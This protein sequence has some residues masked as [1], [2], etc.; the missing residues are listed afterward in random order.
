MWHLL[1]RRKSNKL[2]NFGRE[3]FK[4]HGN[5]LRKMLI[6]C[7]FA[8]LKSRNSSPSSHAINWKRLSTSSTGFF[9]P[10]KLSQIAL[11][12]EY[13]FYNQHTSFPKRFTNSH[14]CLDFQDG[15]WYWYHIWKITR[16]LSSFR[17]RRV[18]YIY[19]IGHKFWPRF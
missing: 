4:C 17:W 16:I 5:V 9:T 6:S 7:Q 18:W 10:T 8:T 19:N 11:N 13:I 12:F 2:I 1:E 14:A 15:L 3:L